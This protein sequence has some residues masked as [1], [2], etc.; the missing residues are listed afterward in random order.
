[1]PP[2]PLIAVL[3]GI[4]PVYGL[5]NHRLRRIPE[6]VV[7][8]TALFGV[9]QDRRLGARDS[10]AMVWLARLAVLM[11]SSTHTGP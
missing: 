4:A 3:L 11:R 8:A 10:R 2:L 1:M 6:E 7:N 9:A 5:L